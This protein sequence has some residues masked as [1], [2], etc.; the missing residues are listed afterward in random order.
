MN[1]LTKQ[2]KAKAQ[3]TIGNKIAFI[4]C[5]NSSSVLSDYVKDSDV[6]TLGDI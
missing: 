1:Q 6:C 5:I 2:I 4:S 3:S